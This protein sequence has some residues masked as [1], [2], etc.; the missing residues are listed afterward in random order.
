MRWFFGVGIILF[1]AE[2]HRTHVG[3]F[4][5]WSSTN[6]VVDFLEW[7]KAVFDSVVK[8]I[9]TDVVT[10]HGGPSLECVP[11][12]NLRLRFSGVVRLEDML[13]QKVT[14]H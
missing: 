11:L 8:V 14:R 1:N 7:W 10:Q 2:R 9:T 5:T 4:Q 6:V 13:N 12:A 3:V